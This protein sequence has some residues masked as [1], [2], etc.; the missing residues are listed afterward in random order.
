MTAVEHAERA[1]ELAVQSEHGAVVE[2]C[3]LRAAK[4]QAHAL[5]ALALVTIET[6][7]DRA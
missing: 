2:L 7:E 5:A 4:A 1:S 6:A 3:M